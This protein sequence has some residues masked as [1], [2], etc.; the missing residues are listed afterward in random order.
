MIAFKTLKAGSASTTFDERQ[1]GGSGGQADWGGY[2]LDATTAAIVVRLPNIS[3]CEG[4]VITFIA[5]NPSARSIVIATP[6][7]TPQRIVMG[8][9]ETAS[10]SNAADFGQV[11]LAC[12]GFR[13]FGISDGTFS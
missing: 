2:I 6:A 12:D 7:G 3:L 5:K 1:I 10:I 13:W 8:G 9:T 4:R 11:I